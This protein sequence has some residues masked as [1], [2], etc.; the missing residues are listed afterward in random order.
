MSLST[1]ITL[2]RKLFLFSG[3]GLVTALSIVALVLLS[4]LASK[5]DI[6]RTAAAQSAFLDERNEAIEEWRGALV[7]YE[8]TGEAESPY[9]ARPM[10]LRIPAVL[11]PAPLADFAGGSA[12]L[13]PTTAVLT[14]W[15][16][17]ADLFSRYEFDNPAPLSIGRLDLSFLVVVLLPL[18]M[19][20]ASFDILASDRE[21]GRAKLVAVQAGQLHRSVWERL[22]LRNA[23]IWA[24]FSVAAVMMALLPASGADMGMRLLHFAA[25][26]AIAWVYGA[27]WF[28]LIALASIV[29]KKGETVA[30]ALFAAWAMF[31]FAVPAVGG[32]LA[33]GLYPPPSRLAFLSEMRK[34]E[35]AA[36]RQTA[37][38]TAGIL[39][40]HPEMT[41]SDEAVPAFF[42][43]AYVAN[44]EAGKRTTPVLIAFEESRN[45]RLSLVSYVQYASPS[46][47]ADRALTA[48]AG[49]DIE[50]AMAY[51]RQAREALAELFD[52]IGPAVAAKQRISLEQFEAIPAFQY[53]ERSLGDILAS[54]A[55]PLAYLVLLGFGLVALA[56]RRL[57]APLE[58]IL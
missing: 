10:N 42:N 34:G 46:L 6:A 36:I 21:G 47:I 14:G 18:I 25:W 49:G 20:A 51:Q 50:R 39:A 53:K 7:A 56:R 5:A 32:A 8:E 41:V 44:R 54:S 48:V 1:T 31:V 37:A 40:D 4:A 19:I 28:G 17:P 57:A 35:V 23:S 16:N 15:A 29:I 45:Q 58:Q 13:Y 52:V 26:L 12:E 24:T 38:L 33:E 11:P 27:F 2:E 22:W 9:D 43:R 3:Q 55:V 30:S